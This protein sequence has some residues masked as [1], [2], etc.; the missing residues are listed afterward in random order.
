ATD[1]GFFFTAND[2]ETLIH[3]PKTFTDEALPAGNAIAARALTRLGLLLGETRYLDAAARTLR[4]AWPM[5]DRYPQA[6]GALLLAL[7]DHLELPTIVIVRGEAR[8]AAQWR[9]ELAKL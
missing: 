7:E 5:L 2:H 8:E 4:A 9:D 1:G 3:R 6:H